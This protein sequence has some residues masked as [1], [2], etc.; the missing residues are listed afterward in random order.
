MDE[1]YDVFFRPENKLAFSVYAIRFRTSEN[2]NL[3]VIVLHGSENETPSFVEPV[4]LIWF[5]YLLVR[6]VKQKHPF[7]GFLAGSLNHQACIKF[8]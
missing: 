3:N 8:A 6:F 5:H 4:D 2:L 7:S 1:F